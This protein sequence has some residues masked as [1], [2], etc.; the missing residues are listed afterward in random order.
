MV[1]VKKIDI[2]KNMNIIVKHII[3]Y[4]AHHVLE[5]TIALNLINIKIVLSMIF[6]RHRAIRDYEDAKDTMSV[7]KD[8]VKQ[9]AGMYDEE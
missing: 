9:L 8:C 5:K 4:V 1:F 3:N 6:A 2:K 7:Y